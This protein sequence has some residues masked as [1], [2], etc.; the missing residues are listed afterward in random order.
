MSLRFGVWSPVCGDWLRVAESSTSSAP[1]ELVQLARSA[2]ELGYDYYYV[3][4]HYL[5]AVHGPEHPVA[6]AWMV[7]AAAVFATKRIRVLTAVQPGF[8]WPGTV[9]KMT[10]TLSGFRPGSIGL[11]VLA[12]WW[13]LEAESYG[14]VWLSHAERYA[15]SAEFLDVIR[16]L[17]SEKALH[18]S[19]RYFRVPGALL[20]PKPEPRPTIL[21]AGESEHAIELA[22]RSADYLFINGDLPERVGR[23]AT[24]V[25][26]LAQERY[27]RSVHVALSA[28]AILEDS[29]RRARERVEQL[30]ARA[31]RDTIAY[32]KNQ[33]DGAVVAHNR[34]N[35][36]A[37]IE[38]NLGLASGLVGAAPR[39]VEQ[40]EAFER[41]G[42]DTVLLK[43]PDT[44]PDMLRFARE[45]L[46]PYKSR[47]GTRA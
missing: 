17:W 10:A 25:K 8:K 37:L 40:L 38:A 35:D 5:N 18:Y 26:E 21:V 23:I 6:D 36:A 45:V 43:F 47:S 9:A 32:F 42:V 14:D 19:G 4:E 24:R 28:F 13:Q 39:I 15:R 33:M 46:V 12:G 11:S 44:R 31:D 3:P 2:D 30:T 34:G 7:S 22:A 1:A 27:G 16:G 29:D 20:E 41:A